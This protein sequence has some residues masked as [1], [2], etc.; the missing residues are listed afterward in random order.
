MGTRTNPEDRRTPAGNCKFCVSSSERQR[1]HFASRY[2]RGWGFYMVFK[3]IAIS[4]F[5]YFFEQLS[6]TMEQ[7]ATKKTQAIVNYPRGPGHLE[8]WNF[9]IF[10]FLYFCSCP[11]QSRSVRKTKVLSNQQIPTWH[12]LHEK[13]RFCSVRFISGKMVKHYRN[14]GGPF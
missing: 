3:W 9:E 5:P 14:S 2:S 1:G 4:W 7:N 12:F 6:P 8:V 10:M 11:R 13:L